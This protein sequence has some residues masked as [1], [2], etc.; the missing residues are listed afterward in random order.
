MLRDWLSTVGVG[1][2]CVQNFVWEKTKKRVQKFSTD[3]Q[4][5]KNELTYMWED[6]KKRKRDFE[7]NT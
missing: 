5:K 2:E 7:S 1:L 6:K 3:P 4:V